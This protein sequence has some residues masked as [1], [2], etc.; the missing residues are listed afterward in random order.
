MYVFSEF[1]Y[2][3]LVMFFNKNLPVLSFIFSIKKEQILYCYKVN[4]FGLWG[5]SAVYLFRIISGLRINL[6]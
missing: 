1:A 3:L 5:Y 4:E 2:I 6:T